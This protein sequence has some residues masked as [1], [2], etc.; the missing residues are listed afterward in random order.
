MPAHKG[1]KYAL[2]NKGG[3]PEK[4][5]RKHCKDIVD[6]FSR[7]HYR[8]RTV[9][10]K[11]GKSTEIDIPNKLPTLEGFAIHLGTVCTTIYGWAER[12]KEFHNALTTARHLQKEMLVQLGLAGD[13]DKVF[14]MFIAK[15]M[16]DLR[17]KTEQEVNVNV[18]LS[19][20]LT[21]LDERNSIKQIARVEDEPNKIHSGNVELISTAGEEGI[22]G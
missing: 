19:Q 13:Y 9:L 17:D 12:H 14:A 4:Y 16:T 5:R 3:R 10:T 6:F 18:S 22:S 15:N 7:D 11:D 21:Q 20:L 2:G 1:N 8:K